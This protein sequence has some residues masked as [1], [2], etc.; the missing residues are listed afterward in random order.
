MPFEPA[1]PQRD[2]ANGDVVSEQ[3][4]MRLRALVEEGLASGPATPMTEAE[5]VE[6][7][8]VADGK[9]A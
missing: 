5:W 2:Q 3:V 8:A 1:L 7:D 6:L 4:L 9:A